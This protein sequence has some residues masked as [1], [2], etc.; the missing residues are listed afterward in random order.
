ME[1]TKHTAVRA[2]SGS[3]YLQIEVPAK[4]PAHRFAQ[5]LSVVA[6]FHKQLHLDGVSSW[7]ASGLALPGCSPGSS[8]THTEGTT[9]IWNEQVK[10]G[11]I[12]Q[13]TSK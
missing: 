6:M 3:S 11:L 7:M 10:P 4:V 9:V 12:F 5:G 1:G 2:D 8:F 13:G